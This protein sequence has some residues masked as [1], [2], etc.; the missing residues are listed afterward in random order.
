MVPCSKLLLLTLGSAS[1]IQ[2]PLRADE[3]YTF[4]FTQTGGKIESFAFSVTVPTF[5]TSGQTPVFTPFTITD[6]TISA[7][8][9]MDLFSN[10]YIGSY[11]YGCFGF[12]SASEVLS[13][14][15]CAAGRTTDTYYEP[16]AWMVF[17]TLGGHVYP[18]LKVTIPCRCRGLSCRRKARTSCPKI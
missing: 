16:L 13:L 7:T 4:T 8:L 17:A 9:A 6:G 11:S 15:P 10:G 2:V 3:I 5:A 1:M 12:A 14:L 18:R